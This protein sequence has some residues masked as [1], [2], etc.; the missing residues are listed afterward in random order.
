MFGFRKLH[1]IH[2]KFDRKC[3]YIE[4][5]NVRLYKRHINFLYVHSFLIKNACVMFPWILRYFVEKCYHYLSRYIRK[6]LLEVVT[7]IES[8][9][10][11][12]NFNYFRH[13]IFVRYLD[14]SRRKVLTIYQAILENFLKLPRPSSINDVLENICSFDILNF[15]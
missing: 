13:K 12:G 4:A 2:Y 5:F 1:D 3:F 6:K 7:P 11:D 15:L 9:I 10:N 14:I 8:K